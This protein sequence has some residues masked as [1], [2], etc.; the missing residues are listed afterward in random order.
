MTATTTLSAEITAIMGDATDVDGAPIAGLTHAQGRRELTTHT[1]PPRVVWVR[2]EGSPATAVKSS[3]PTG[4]RSILTRVM[5]LELHCWGRDEDE[6]DALV[7]AVL[8]A[9]HR[10]W[11]GRWEYQG[12]TWADEPVQTELGERAIVRITVENAV[13]DRPKVSVNVETAN[14]DPSSAAPGDGVL[15]L[16]ETS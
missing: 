12:E 13:L 9:C 3:F 5:T 6:T 1:S 14:F 10:R 16:G 11:R 15:H 7:A 8:A 2:V 4:T